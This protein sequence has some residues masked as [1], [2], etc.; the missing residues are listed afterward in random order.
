MLVGGGL[1]GVEVDL[2]VGVNDGGT[3]GESASDDWTTDGTGNSAVAGAACAQALKTN[4]INSNV[5]DKYIDCVLIEKLLCGLV[6]SLVT[7]STCDRDGC[8]LY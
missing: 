1:V 6:S 5:T 4:K 2:R 7:T 8:N 3:V